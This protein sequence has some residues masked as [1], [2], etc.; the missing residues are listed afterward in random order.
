VPHA[1]EY[2]TSFA[3]TSTVTAW[4]Y[5]TWLTTSAS[6]WSWVSTSGPRGC[7]Q[8]GILLLPEH[9]GCGV[10][11]GAQLLLA[12]YLFAHT[13]ANRPEA[14]TESTTRPSSTHRRRGSREGLLR[15]RGWGNG[16]WRDGYVRTTSP[17]PHPRAAH[18]VEQVE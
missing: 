9:R 4:L 8:I 2:A 12:E 10:G 17:I 14:T 15:G 13:T 1:D 7:V 6:C 11:T 16:E 18:V 3:P 5:S